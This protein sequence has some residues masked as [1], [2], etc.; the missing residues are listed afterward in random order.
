MHT[1]LKL[2]EFNTYDLEYL[3]INTSMFSIGHFRIVQEP[4]KPLKLCGPGTGPIC[5]MMAMPLNGA[6]YSITR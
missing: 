2:T 5:P 4:R 1:L 3:L 6:L